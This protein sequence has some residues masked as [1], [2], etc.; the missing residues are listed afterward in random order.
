MYTFS[1]G[2]PDLDQ[3]FIQTTRRRSRTASRLFHLV[4]PLKN[5]A[6]A[7][8]TFSISEPAD[9]LRRGYPFYFLKLNRMALMLILTRKIQLPGQLPD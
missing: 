3:E 8:S 1:P 2:H 4:A 6:S 5:E 7:D 9:Q